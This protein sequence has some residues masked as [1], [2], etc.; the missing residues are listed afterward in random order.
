M[1]RSIPAAAEEDEVRMTCALSGSRWCLFAAALGPAA[2]TVDVHVLGIRI[3]PALTQLG[4]SAVYFTAKLDT[5]KSVG[6]DP[7]RLFI[8]VREDLTT[9]TSWMRRSVPAAAGED[10]V[11]LRMTCALSKSRWCLLPPP[12]VTPP[13]PSMLMRRSMSSVYTLAPRW[14]CLVHS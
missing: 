1:R 5:A 2:I 3:G 14:P 10:E 9:A 6:R 8:M 13:P 4:H 11:R 12:L 7:L